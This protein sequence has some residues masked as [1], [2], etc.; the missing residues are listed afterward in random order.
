MSEDE[1]KVK[2]RRLEPAIQK[3]IKIVIPT[4]LERLR[5]HQINIEKYQRCRIWDKLHEEHI[6]AGRT[7]QQLRSNIREMEKL[8]LKVRKDDLVLLKRMID[9]VKEEASAATAEF[10]Q[11]H[12]ESV[13]ELKKQFNDEE[14]L[15]QPSL[16]RSMTVG[17]TFHTAEA[18]ADPQTM[19]QVYALPEI[20]RDQ[21]AAE[22]WETLE[23]DLIELS[24]LVTDF[25][26]L[27][28]SQQEKID[29]IED[30]VNRAAVNVE[31]GTKNLGKA[32]KYKLAA[33][34]VAGALIGGVVGGPIGLLAGFKVAGIAA[35]LGGGVLGFT[36]GKLIQRKKQK[37][38]E[39]LT[40]SCPD[41]PSQT[42][43][44]CS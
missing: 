39:K 4:D 42:D 36:G 25:S 6:N 35:A 15:L 3:F 27:V 1:E 17:G 29:S 24:Q 11:L 32:A 38:M 23:A 9:P 2:L 7:V 26:L 40:S 18:E 31:E 19:T 14:T 34:P 37:M 21:N 20:P 12:L 13:E 5:K 10:L 33:L 43:K 30:H 44:K 22:S 16:T 41:L 8:C 28:N